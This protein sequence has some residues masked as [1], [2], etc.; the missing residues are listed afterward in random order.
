VNWKICYLPIDG[1]NLEKTS[2][3]QHLPMEKKLRNLLPAGKF[4]GVSAERSQ[5]MRAV[6]GK[7]NRTTENRLRS[8]LAK[9]MIRGWKVRQPGVTGNPD[10]VFPELKI[11]IFVD[12]CFWHGCPTCGHIPKTNSRYWAAKIASN[13]RRDKA[14][15]KRLRIEGFRVLRL[16]EHSLKQEASASARKIR[17]LLKEVLRCKSTKPA[18]LRR[19]QQSI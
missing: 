11:A 2:N 6:K 9:N 14:N 1:V 15:N 17:L 10:F 12:G 7:G 8:A 19:M 18:R 4:S 3:A 5:S 13:R 16:W